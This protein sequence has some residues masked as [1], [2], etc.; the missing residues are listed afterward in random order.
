MLATAL[1][2][3]NKRVALIGAGWIGLEVAATARTLG[4]DVR[5]LEHGSV[6]LGSALGIELGGYFAA[7]H[8]KNGVILETSTDVQEILAKDGTVA[9]VR[10]RNNTV[11]P[12]D[13][14][15]VAVGAQPN[16]E[17]AADAG[18]EVDNGILVDASLTTSDPNIFAAG[19][20]ANAMHPVIGQRLRSEHWANALNQGPAAARSML[21]QKVSYD[22]IPYFYTDQFDLGMEY[23]GY[24]PL[25]A[26]AKVVYRGDRDSGE[27]IAFWV[28]DGKV[29]AGM[30]VN[31]W[32]VNEDIQ[33]I[34]RR[35]N[36][37]DVARLADPD[38]PLGE[39]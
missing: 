24:A 34:I 20:V 33:G 14:V 29:V 10:T 6:P 4:N 15:V 12:A 2:D 5:V 13:V 8:E 7:L 16:V 23:S 28:A 30:N 17:L 11:V 3:G 26:N 22:E 32:D 21:G 36:T 18:L 27:F 19:D 39:L 35:A 9:G 25:A 37:V 1:V 38:V 31:V